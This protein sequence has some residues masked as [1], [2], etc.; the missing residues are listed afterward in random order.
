MPSELNR[1]YKVLV[2][3]DEP[4]I[5]YLFEELFKD[6]KWIKIYTADN[7]FEGL[8]EVK[9]NTFDLVISDIQMPQMMG[10]QLLQE[11]RK[12]SPSS[13]T[14]LITGYNVEQYLQIALNYGITNI[15]TKDHAFKIDWVRTYIWNLLTRNIFGL[16]NYLKRPSSRLHRLYIDNSRMIFPVVET[17][18]ETFS[19]NNIEAD[20]KLPVTEILTNAFYHSHGKPNNSVNNEKGHEHIQLEPHN[21]I[22]IEYGWDDTKLGISVTDPMGTLKKEDILYHLKRNTTIG[23]DGLPENIYDTRGRGFF[24]VW[25]NVDRMIVNVSADEKTEVIVL[26]FFEQYRSKGR[27]HPLFINEI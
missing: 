9:S 19:K 23:Q 15:I 12:L 17:I 13:K 10:Y 1:I 3:D 16:K 25:Y 7:P 22:F 18:H 11:V 26:N 4:S 24:L 21:K 27:L 8:K 20:L 6:E 5:L 2:V 14:A